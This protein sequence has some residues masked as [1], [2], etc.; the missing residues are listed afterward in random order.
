MKKFILLLAVVFFFCAPCNATPNAQTVAAIERMFSLTDM[1]KVLD[2][3]YERME[4]E[5]TYVVN[6][7]DVPVAKKPEL[8]RRFKQMSQMMRSKMNWAHFKGPMIAA[9]SKAF[10]TEE[11]EQMIVFYQTPLG[12]KMLEKMPQLQDMSMQMMQQQ[13][14]TLMPKL[15]EL[16]HNMT[17][18]FA[19][20]D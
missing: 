20:L 7:M 18:E 11:I 16:Q 15:K 14:L 10:T 13:M 4:S 2:K 19:R 8:E 12:R 3:M 6:Q 1:D 5:F 9:Y 17:V